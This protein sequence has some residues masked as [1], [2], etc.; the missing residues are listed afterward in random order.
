MR[1]IVTMLAMITGDSR[2][3]SGT[4]RQV[5]PSYVV[6]AQIQLNDIWCPHVRVD[7]A[8]FVKPAF[9]VVRRIEQRNP[10]LTLITPSKVS[11][12]LFQVVF[13]RERVFLPCAS[14][15]NGAPILVRDARLRR[16]NL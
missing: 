9:R 7:F 16:S 4:E 5:R 12:A 2:R 15:Q 11:H 6:C 3:V 14:S 13:K 10:A 8:A 1:S